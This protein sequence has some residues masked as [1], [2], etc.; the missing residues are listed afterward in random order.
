MALGEVLTLGTPPAE[1]RTTKRMDAMK[2]FHVTRRLGP[3]LVIAAASLK[4]I[5]DGKNLAQDALLA[6]AG[7]VMQ[8]VSHMSDEDVE[9]IIRTCLATVERKQGDTF[10]PVMT[11]D[12]KQ[13]MFADMDQAVMIRMTIE[14]IY[15]NLENFMPGTSDGDDSPTKSAK[16]TRPY[17]T[18][19]SA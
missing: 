10:A 6:V 19:P 5:L 17:V 3:A 4:S 16:A 9:Y 7:P 1:Y 15:I 13:F 11:P 18:S 8:I 2:Q 14:V 12:G